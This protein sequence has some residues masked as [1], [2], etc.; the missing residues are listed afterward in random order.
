MRTPAKA[1]SSTPS[2]GAPSTPA[3]G[4]IMDKKSPPSLR[5]KTKLA[6]APLPTRHGPFKVRVYR[7]E[8]PTALP[9]LSNEHIALVRGDVRGQRRVPVRVHSECLTS[10]V[11]GSLKCDCR[12]QLVRTQADIAKRDLGIILYLRQEGRGIGLVLARQVAEA[13]GGSL[14]LANRDD[15]PGCIASLVIPA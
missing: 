1:R 15:G 4:I 6:A 8:D 3:V 11:F 12:E 5:S 7:W 10:E 2:G 14:N 9:G 13:H